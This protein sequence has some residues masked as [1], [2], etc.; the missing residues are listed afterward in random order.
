M[1]KFYYLM[2]LMFGFVS[3]T[4]CSSDDDEKTPVTV[5]FDQAKYTFGSA[6][7]D[8]VVITAKANPAFEEEC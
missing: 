1:K 4:S 6:V 5:S 7:G 8:K 2:A 3:L